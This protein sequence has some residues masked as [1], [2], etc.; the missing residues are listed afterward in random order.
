MLLHKF[1]VPVCRDTEAVGQRQEAKDSPLGLWTQE[2]AGAVSP[3]VF[4]KEKSCGPCADRGPS[5]ENGKR[6]GGPQRDTCLRCQGH[7]VKPS[8]LTDGNPSWGCDL[9]I[10]PSPLAI[11][12]T[13]RGQGGPPQ[14]GG[15]AWVEVKRWPEGAA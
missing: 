7:R 5:L 13:F 11:M 10:P 8:H 6:G 4:G 2:D 14:G 15:G 3:G 9:P 12:L 1:V